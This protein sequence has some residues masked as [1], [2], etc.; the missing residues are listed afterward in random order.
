MLQTSRRGR[1]YSSKTDR[2]VRCAAPLPWV[3]EGERTKAKPASA[4]SRRCSTKP[5]PPQ[6]SEAF[7]DE[8][9]GARSKGEDI[10][11]HSNDV[12]VEAPR[13]PRRRSGVNTLATK[14]FEY[15][16][17]SLRS[18]LT[19]RRSSTRRRPPTPFPHTSKTPCRWRVS[20]SRPTS[21]RQSKV[22]L[23]AFL[24]GTWVTEAS[25]EGEYSYPVQSVA[26]SR[27]LTAMDQ[28]TRILVTS[29]LPCASI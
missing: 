12:I 21:P 26:S 16:G 18:S 22:V 28:H 4:R 8:R 13:T 23:P 24:S 6:Q 19:C 9:S 29:D 27:E 25:D 3:E 7:C 1:R 20:Y 17:N 15:P 10:R 14:R 5:P 2:T 11:W